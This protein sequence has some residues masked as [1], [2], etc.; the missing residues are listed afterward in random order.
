[1]QASQGNAYWQAKLFD[2]QLFWSGDVHG[3]SHRRFL[4]VDR[5]FS[6]D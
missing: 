6:F 2:E 3:D 5:V 1:L 4:P